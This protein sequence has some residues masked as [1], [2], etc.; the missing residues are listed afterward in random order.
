[1]GAAV[2]PAVRAAVGL[3]VGAAVGLAVRAAVG[4]AVRA[5]VG[6]AVG[7]PVGLIWVFLV[8]PE[9]DQKE[10]YKRLKGDLFTTS[11]AYHSINCF[12]SL[13]NSS[14]ATAVFSQYK[15]EY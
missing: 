2:G 15:K 8:R 12:R 4:L 10:T 9:R 6:L 11:D 1:V 7:A 5:A 13:N 3:A 14:S